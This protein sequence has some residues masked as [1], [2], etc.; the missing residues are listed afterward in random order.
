VKEYWYQKHDS[1]VSFQF[2]VLARK[3]TSHFVAQLSAIIQIDSELDPV[4]IWDAMQDS[5]YKS[6]NEIEYS[7]DATWS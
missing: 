5:E 4:N 1:E 6:Q 2:P 7:M 3:Q